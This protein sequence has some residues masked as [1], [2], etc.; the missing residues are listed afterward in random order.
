MTTAQRF[1][2]VAVL[3]AVSSPSAGAQANKAAASS[4]PTLTP[5]S[6]SAPI[7]NAVC[8][9]MAQVMTPLQTLV[10]QYEIYATTTGDASGEPLAVGNYRVRFANLHRI[11]LSVTA[12]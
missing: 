5:E 8:V 10:Q 12:S 9:Q 6:G 4:A 2:V 7:G 11:W 3:M 1:L